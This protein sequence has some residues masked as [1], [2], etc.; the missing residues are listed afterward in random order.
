MRINYITVIL[1]PV[2][3]TQMIY[4]I[5]NNP[6][7][8]PYKV[9]RCNDQANGQSSRYPLALHR[10]ACTYSSCWTKKRSNKK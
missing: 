8:N 6:N 2:P 9:A 7:G 10:L 1:I 3:L 5:K 4:I